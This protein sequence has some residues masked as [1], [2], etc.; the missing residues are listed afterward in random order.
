MS[1][2]WLHNY[3]KKLKKKA[4]KQKPDFDEISNQ[5]TDE[6]R[7][8][9]IEKIKLLANRVCEE[10]FPDIAQDLKQL[11]TN[12]FQLKGHSTKSEFIY[13]PMTTKVR[14]N[15]YNDFEKICST[16]KINKQFGITE[17]L[18]DWIEKKNTEK[19]TN[20][21]FVI[22]FFP[23]SYKIA[24]V[25]DAVINSLG[26]EAQELPISDFPDESKFLI[27]LKIYRGTLK[28][29]AWTSTIGIMKILSF[30]IQ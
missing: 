21:E 20:R 29:K 14:G 19:L 28:A 15:V 9:V 6:E 1:V 18:K 11:A 4:K 2:Y 13:L 16:N 17:A 7:S 23:L 26:I 25:V 3:M 27:P 24:N 5:M 8:L 12:E 30:K 22:C 10:G